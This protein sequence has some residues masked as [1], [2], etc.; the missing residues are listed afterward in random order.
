MSEIK[1]LRLG[2]LKHVPQP[3]KLDEN[4][5]IFERFTA[6]A[7]DDGVD[8]FITC[9]GFLDGYYSHD[10]NFDRS[11]FLACAQ[12]INESSYLDRVREI[13]KKR[14]MHILFGFSWKLK[15]GV[16][17]AALL[18]D[19]DGRDLGI[20][21]KTHLLDQD[22]QNY[23]RGDELSVVE[24]RLGKFGIM[25]C[26]D[27]RWPEVPRALK[28]MGSDL[29]LTPSY[30]MW[31]EANE[32]LM[33]VRAYENELYIAF[34]HPRVSFV[35]DPRGDVA[36]KLLSNVTDILVCDI[37]MSDRVNEMVP[38]RQTDLY[39]ALTEE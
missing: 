13:A 3:L 20:C 29:I 1:T 17:N 10:E 8:L 2:L 30:G 23:I 4:M 15:Q 11:Q 37:D 33:R 32:R 16:K 28:L 9:E 24:S 19:S 34:A 25:I 7:C 35:C 38:K 18:V 22:F 5:E 31:D 26:A 14:S 21:C 6:K 36:A 12:N 39:G 27:R